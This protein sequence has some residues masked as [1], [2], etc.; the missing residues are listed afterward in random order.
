MPDKP[1]RLQWCLRQ[2][3]GIRLTKPSENLFKAYQQK[4]REALRSMEVN[5]EA[6]IIDWTV[7]ASYYAKYFAVYAILCRIG[8]KC[9]I[10]DCTIELFAY[11]FRKEVS[12]HH[13]QD[14]RESKDERIEHQYYTSTKKVDAKTLSKKTED[15]VL[16][17][18]K[19][20]DGLNNQ[21]ITTLQSELKKLSTTSQHKGMARF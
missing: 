15:F 19:L 11:L 1:S 20:A 16:E 2:R 17:L 14:L 13:I 7:S 18:E 9:E 3:Y 10:H 4:S 12:A 5:A 8:A 6:G 21:K